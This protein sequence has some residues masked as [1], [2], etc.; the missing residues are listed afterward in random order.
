MVKQSWFFKYLSL[1]VLF[2]IVLLATGCTLFGPEPLPNQPVTDETKLEPSDPRYVVELLADEELAQIFDS[3]SRTLF[4]KD[5]KSVYEGN[6][7]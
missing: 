2:L 1:A 5:F 3:A 7:M 6:L 4:A